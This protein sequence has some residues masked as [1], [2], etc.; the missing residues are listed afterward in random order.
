[1]IEHYVVINK[2]NTHSTKNLCKTKTVKFIPII[3]PTIFVIY[4]FYLLQ[5]LQQYI[6]HKK[7]FKV[8]CCDNCLDLF[9]LRKMYYFFNRII[10]NK[11]KNKKCRLPFELL[12]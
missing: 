2:Q 1:M 11:N 9:I 8:L 12:T 5:D 6:L 10:S 7:I 4:L 3:L